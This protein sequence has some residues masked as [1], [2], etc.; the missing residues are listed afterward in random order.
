MQT[1]SEISLSLI[2]DNGIILFIQT[3]T[4]AD[5]LPG[6]TNYRP[7]SGGEGKFFYSSGASI[8]MDL[9]ASGCHLLVGVINP[10]AN[11]VGFSILFNE[12]SGVNVIVIII[13]VMGG[14]IF[15]GLVI[16]AIIILRKLHRSRREV[17]P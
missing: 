4:F 5:E 7:E 3:Q 1:Q 17:L 15:L 16:S 13:G 11:S 8:S 2:F 14:I 9:S 12:K 6:I 10:H